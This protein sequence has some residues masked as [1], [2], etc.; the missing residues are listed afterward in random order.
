MWRNNAR[1]HDKAIPSLRD[2]STTLCRGIFCS[3]PLTEYLKAC[4]VKSMVI[5]KCCRTQ[6]LF[7]FVGKTLFTF[8]FVCRFFFLISFLL[9]FF[10]CICMW[11]FNFNL[12]LSWLGWRMLVKQKGHMLWGRTFWKCLNYVLLVILPNVLW[13]L[14]P[15]HLWAQNTSQTHQHRLCDQHCPENCHHVKKIRPPSLVGMDSRCHWEL[16][17]TSQIC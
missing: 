3:H 2:T 11:F 4:H 10:N 7:S 13:Q 15:T 17:L 6:N 5:V 12:F 16:A 1:V 8:W 14:V 9:C